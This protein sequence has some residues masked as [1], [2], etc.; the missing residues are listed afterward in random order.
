MKLHPPPRS[1]KEER[2]FHQRFTTA[3]ERWLDAG[4][5]RCV[6]QSPRIRD[7]ATQA[8]LEA[9]ES[10]GELWSI[11]MMP[12][13]VHLLASCRSDLPLTHLVRNAKGRSAREINRSQETEGT[14]WARDYFDRLIR[15]DNHFWACARY[16]RRNPRKA[17][18]RK[19]SYTLLEHPR[20]RALL[21]QDEGGRAPCP[22]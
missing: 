5:G 15:D 17:G 12:N 8:I 7:R 10:A 22:D 21:D 4:H 11:V 19:H 20:V 18:L 6:L 3:K 14:V 1:T 16:I 13:H 2:E 9:C